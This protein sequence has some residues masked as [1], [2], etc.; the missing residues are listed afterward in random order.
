MRNVHPLLSLLFLIILSSCS[1]K[2]TPFTQELYRENGWTKSDLQQIQFYVSRDVVLRREATQGT[3]KI[4]SGEIKIVD[5]KRVEQIVIRK[6]TPGVFLFSP[7]D[8]RFAV[9]FESR[10][11]SEDPYLIFGPSRQT[12]GQYVLRARDWDDRGRG[13]K[14]S[15][16]QKTYYTPT[17][18]AYAAL[19]VDLKR[20][21]N[22][23]VKS[24]TAD[25]RTIRN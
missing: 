8:D 18:S 23:K 10:A 25:G 1:P 9:S 22:T 5:G 24:R 2:L 20:I 14:I 15:Y 17:E 3:S 12:R 6:G 7:K 16:G 11:G 13:G 4:E 19:L 21:R